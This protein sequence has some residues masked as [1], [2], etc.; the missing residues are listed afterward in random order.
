VFVI[1]DGALIRRY[2]THDHIW[3]QEYQHFVFYEINKYL[4]QKLLAFHFPA[5]P[6]TEP[7]RDPK[8]T[9]PTEP[10]VW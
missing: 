4:L 8:T 10:W 1:P 6:K 3:I 9:I 2:M 5:V 7:N